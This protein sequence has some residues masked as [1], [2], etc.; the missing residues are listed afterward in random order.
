MRSISATIPTEAVW[1]GGDNTNMVIGQGDVLVTPMQVA[2][3]YGAIATGNL[4]KPHL[5]K[6]VRNASGGVVRSF[7]PEVVGSPT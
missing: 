3:A 5:L 7:E 4:M 2:V 6:E 1:K